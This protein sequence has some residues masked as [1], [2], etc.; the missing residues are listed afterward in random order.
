MK[1]KTLAKKPEV[2]NKYAQKE[3]DKAEAQFE[4]FNENVK[5]LT[6]DRMNEAPKEQTEPQTK[7]S[8]REAQ[9]SDA[10]WLTPKRTVSSAEKFNEKYRKD[11]EF[12]REYV[13]FIAE[14]KEL[15]GMIETWTKPFA[16]M[17]AEFWE[18]PCNRPVLGPRYLAERIKN[19]S[20]HRLS[21]DET[22][23]TGKD[24]YGAW[25]GSIVVDSIVQRLDAIPVS[26]KKSIFLGASSF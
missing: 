9:K 2:T 26:D 3:L 14:N 22:K 11:Y 24:G 8:T 13:R 10:T 4:A 25:T 20:Y 16:G 23:I 15:G 1:E 5:S 19:C 21:M 6:L 7:M 18:V 17:D 12:A